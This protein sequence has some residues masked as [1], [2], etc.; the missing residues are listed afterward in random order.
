MN[1][2]HLVPAAPCPC[3]KGLSLENCCLPLI[4]GISPA[5]SAE[6]LMR[7]RYTAYVM[8]D[9]AYLS[10]SWHVSTR[11]AQLD[12]HSSIEWLGLTIISIKAGAA[13]DQRGRVEFIARYQ[14]LDFT[15]QAHEDS[16]F[17]FEQ[18]RWFYLDGDVKTEKL[19][20]RN[21]PCSCGRGKKFKKCCGK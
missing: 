2:E 12:L 11:P 3:G 13:D 14:Q 8:R 17:I 16:R 1:T 18:D 21:M 10:A 6:A 9:A 5:V 20:G 4:R 7:S 19:T 15:G